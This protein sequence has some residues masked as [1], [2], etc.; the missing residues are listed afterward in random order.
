[1]N[2]AFNHLIAPIHRYEGTIAR[3]LG[4]GFL[5][6]FGAPV[7]HEDDPVR[8]VLAG[9]GI[10]HDL[11]PFRAE[12]ASDYGLDFNVRVGI[13][14][15]PVVVG[16]IGAGQALEY[17]AM[18][19]AI[20][21]AHRMEATAAPGTIQIAE[22]TYR[23]VAPLFEVEPLGEMA[24]KGKEAPVATYQ[25]TGRRERPGR[26]RGI[27]GL[28]AP[29]VG[30]DAE[31]AQLRARLDALKGGRGQIVFLIGEAGLGKSRL[32]SEM[33]AYWRQ[34]PGSERY[35][36]EA[37]G[38]P[39]ETGRPYSLFYRSIRNNLGILDGDTPD[40]V[41][42]KIDQVLVEFP[43]TQKAA[44]CQA[45]ETLLAVEGRSEG[46]QLEAKAL[47][48]QL[49]D[50]T[51]QVWRNEGLASPSVTVFD[52]L[53]WSDP[54]SAELIIHL[55]Q[56]VDELPVMI[57][58]AMRPHRDS[59][60][61]QI[62]EKA[63]EVYPAYFSEFTL[64]PLDGQHSNE[65]VDHLLVIAD[66]HEDLRW[67]IQEK[68]EGNPFFLEEVV[69]ALIE[70]GAIVK[71]EDDGRW[72]AAQAVESLRLP[73]NL[74][75]MLTSRID[76]LD[77]QAKRTLQ[78]ASVIGRKFSRRVLA[79]IAES[80]RQLD[81]ELA[82][83]QQSELILAANANGQADA[84]Y[85]FR[86][87]LTRDA[88]YQTLL[89]RQRR[90]YHRRAGEAIETLFPE[91]LSEEA[92]RLAYHFGQAGDN[93]RALKYYELAGEKAARLYANKEAAGHYQQ[94]IALAR[95]GGD[96]QLLLRLYTA[97]GRVLTFD[98]RF[99]EALA[100][101]QEL[102][103]LAEEMGDPN[104]ALEALVAQGS[105]F[106][107]PSVLFD[108][109]RA[110]RLLNEALEA[111]R[112]LGNETVE[113]KIQW[114]LMIINNNMGG[115]PEKGLEHGQRS[116]ALARKHQL[117]E[118]LA[119]TL[120][121]LARPLTLLNRFDEALAN[122]QEARRLF[123]Q[124]NNMPMV[125]DNMATASIGY[126]LI[127][128]L[129]LSLQLGRESMV[130]GREIGSIWGEGYATMHIG[131]ALAELGYVGQAIRVWDRAIGLARDASVIGMNFFVP[132]YMALYSIMVGAYDEGERLIRQLQ[133]VIT[134]APSGREFSMRIKVMADTLSHL[135]ALLLLGRGDVHGAQQLD[136]AQIPETAF[137]LLDATLY[138]QLK[139]IEC[140][141][142]LAS[143][144][145]EQAA[146]LAESARDALKGI[147][148]TITLPL[149]DRRLAQAL[150]GME[151]GQKART[152]LGQ[153]AQEARAMQARRQL[154]P[155]L[156]L[157][158][159]LAEA[160]E[161]QGA[162]AA[163]RREAR[164][165]IELMAADLDEGYRPQFLALPEVRQAAG[166]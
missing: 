35:W 133:E 37:Q 143:A 26:V 40:E 91:R 29:L 140:S 83:L 84:E 68:A 63:A 148:I 70:A 156:G 61:W 130:L 96:S 151:Q 60:G 119:Y 34:E 109:K 99:D 112:T 31:M 12:M 52:D 128:K 33:A 165:I 55:F 3:L 17:T 149:L 62:K 147:G 54:A 78:M 24:V 58:C 23:Q 157:L 136:L 115:P 166:L 90:R 47:K 88:A 102:R 19:D 95:G 71:D 22:H 124:Q 101:S 153:A 142:L 7:A 69:R 8:A 25:V 4:D 28:E 66:L 104:L 20:N 76:R 141:V 44:I 10:L 103:L 111:A 118:Q 131:F 21:L 108:A 48:R 126:F 158:A 56:L 123:R 1:M 16:E 85:V 139:G 154:W 46:P 161:E 162:A 116:L 2:E 159:S 15:G 45:V 65:L 72:R 152:I 145:Y 77:A 110:R 106:A 100:S 97:L 5:A 6:F 64:E 73:E 107:V 41:Q 74:Q 117:D 53:Q 122:L 155:I 75:A 42:Q 13:N 137:N 144:E 132:S 160:D 164:E 125:V 87:E 134:H 150:L 27:R 93:G 79:H 39:Y 135:E 9:L 59:P 36:T 51:T 113:A 18:G 14:T 86:H 146:R 11:A 32:L 57:L 49:F 81:D 98:G 105:L 30:R 80:D 163:L 89:R 120:H 43:A 94:A 127:G 67:L 38:V 114:S 82:A 50:L 129:D 138:G 92:H 121:D